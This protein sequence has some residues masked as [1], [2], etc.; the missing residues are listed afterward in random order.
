MHLPLRGTGIVHLR[1]ACQGRETIP[2]RG[3]DPKHPCNMLFRRT[4]VPRQRGGQDRRDIS[5][6]RV[7]GGAPFH[8]QVRTELCPEQRLNLRTGA[9]SQREESLPS[10]AG[11][12]EEDAHLRKRERRPVQGDPRCVADDREPTVPVAPRAMRRQTAQAGGRARRSRQK[13]RSCARSWRV[14]PVRVRLYVMSGNPAS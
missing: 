4:V 3:A 1:T 6:P 7:V 11:A 13:A 9:I 10:K 8:R 5:H 2:P 14:I 12:A